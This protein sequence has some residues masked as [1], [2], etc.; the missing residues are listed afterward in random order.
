MTMRYFVYMYKFVT[1]GQGSSDAAGF[2]NRSPNHLQYRRTVS[3]HVFGSLAT[4]KQTKTPQHKWSQQ[5]PALQYRTYTHEASI[6]LARNKHYNASR[7]TGPDLELHE[8]LCSTV[9]RRS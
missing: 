2:Q 1:K 4:C 8:S 7:I 5:R 9:R 6:P 3:H